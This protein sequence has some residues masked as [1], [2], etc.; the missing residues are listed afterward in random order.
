MSDRL[1]GLLDPVHTAV[2]TMELQVGVVGPDSLFPA[3]T[4]AVAEANLLANA[5]R[6]CMAARSAGVPV[7]HA[8][9]AHRPDGAGERVNNRIA[10]MAAKRRAAGLAGAVDA[11]TPG[12][13]VV[14]ELDPQPRDVVVSRMHGLTP[15]TGTELDAVLRNL[16][17]RTVVLMGVSLNVGVMGAALSA[18]DLGYDVV[19][20]S[21][22]VTAVPP[23]YGRWVLEHTMPMIATVAP[24]DAVIDALARHGRGG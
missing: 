1:A 6:V 12:A 13:E 4:A 24:A 14:A 15:F 23:E 19:L 9:A 10:A 21:D 20:V 17:V 11:G 22:A 3:L 18:V 8:V 5:G 2:L 16:G 7:V